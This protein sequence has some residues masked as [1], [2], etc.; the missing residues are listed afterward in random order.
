[1][2]NCVRP[3]LPSD[4]R[5]SGTTLVE[6]LVVLAIVSILAVTAIPF[7]ENAN[8]RR[9]E[10]D[11]RESLRIVRSAI[12]AFHADW[13]SGDVGRTSPAASENGY[14]V[15]LQVLVRGVAGSGADVGK[16]RYLRR[17]PE[18]PFTKGTL[19]INAQWLYLGYEDAPDA[20][21][22]NGKDVYDLRAQTDTTALDGSQIS[23]W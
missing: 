10:Y 1:M 22:W 20:V 5:D 13:Q 16:M 9:R 19:E 6:M 12:D 14:P 23:D 21:R 7:A 15:T 11:L 3:E 2:L 8:Q 17:I 4:R 18:N